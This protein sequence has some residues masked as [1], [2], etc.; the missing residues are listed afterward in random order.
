MWGSRTRHTIFAGSA[1]ALRQAGVTLG[2]DV[3]GTRFCPGDPVT[4]G[5]MAA[6]LVRALDAPDTETPAANLFDDVA[7]SGFDAEIAR[8][9]GLGITQG[10]DVRR[11]CPDQLV[12]R[13]Q[14]AV[15]LSRALD[16]G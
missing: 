5:Q 13:G 8:L 4:R 1:A 15:F 9:A 7:G 6:F 14:M 3:S 12:T 10:C 11:F 16:L 2:C